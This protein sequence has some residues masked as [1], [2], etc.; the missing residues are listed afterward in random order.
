MAWIHHFNVVH[1]NLKLS[2]IN[3]GGKK[4]KKK[5]KNLTQPTLHGSVP[6][7]QMYNNKN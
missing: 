1:R 3:T 7:Q 6:Q 2:K 4:K 5:K